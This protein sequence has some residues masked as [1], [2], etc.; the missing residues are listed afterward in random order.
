MQESAEESA[1]Y[2]PALE[3]VGWDD[4]DD[5]FGVLLDSQFF[6]LPQMN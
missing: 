6:S 4:W 1:N 3:R 5:A 2:G